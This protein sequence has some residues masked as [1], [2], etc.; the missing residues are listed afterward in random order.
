MLALS[1]RSPVAEAA[2]TAFIPQQATTGSAS[3]LRLADALYVVSV[4][5]GP[6][7]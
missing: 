5:P 6:S 3:H 7:T 2:I 1:A 4:R